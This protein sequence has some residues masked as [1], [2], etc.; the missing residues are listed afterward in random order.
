MDNFRIRNV[1]YGVQVLAWVEHHR[2][3]APCWGLFGVRG[4]GPGRHKSS[5][6]G[7]R[8]SHPG[9]AKAASAIQ[10]LA[11]AEYHRFVISMLCYIPGELAVFNIGGC[12]SE[13]AYT[14]TL[15]PAWCVLAYRVLAWRHI[16]VSPWLQERSPRMRRSGIDNTGPGSGGAPTASSDCKAWSPVWCLLGVQVLAWAA[17]RRSATITLHNSA[18]Q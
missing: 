1:V 14:E 8:S 3:V 4:L 2:F 11:W 9:C 6:H 16:A 10:G 17:H 13:D 7:C 12:E 5:S 18:A 15:N